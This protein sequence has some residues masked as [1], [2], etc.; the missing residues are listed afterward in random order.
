MSTDVLA[1]LPTRF[2]LVNALPATFFAVLTGALL[3]A[4]APG[5]APGWDNLV[6]HGRRYGWVGAVGAMALVTVTALLLEPLELASIRLLEGYWSAR[7]PLGRAA[8]F[9]RWIQR[10]RR[11]RVEFLLDAAL[12]QGMP[13]ED[14]QLQ[15]ALM[16]QGELLPTALG[17]RLRSFEEKA[18]RAYGLESTELWPRLY[19]VLPEPVLAYVGKAR[20]QLDTASRLCLTFIL[21]A[22]VSAVLLAGHPLWYALPAGSALAA[23]A[24]YRS[25]LAAADSFGIAVTAAIDVYRLRL[26]QEMRVDMP[27]DTAAERLINETLRDLWTGD[28]TASVRYAPADSDILVIF[29]NLRS[30]RR[31][32]PRS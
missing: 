23:A 19:Y 18:G 1:D 11:D 5:E 26:L 20:N 16:P 12:V 9:G 22:L 3:L 15:L 8:E 7:G 4:G 14:L 2:K 30:G 21:S 27:A 17:N 13:T 29:K 28:T 24:S 6:E 31:P 25:A 10:Q 32:R